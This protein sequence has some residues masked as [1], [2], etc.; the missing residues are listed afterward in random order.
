MATQT[1]SKTLTN[2]HVAVAT[3]ILLLAAGSA[4]F[5]AMGRPP[6]KLFSAMSV[7]CQDGS[8]MSQDQYILTLYNTATS[9]PEI[10]PAAPCMTSSEAQLLAQ[11][12]CAGKSNP[13]TRKV[14]VNKFS[15]SGKC[16]QAPQQ[17][18]YGYALYGYE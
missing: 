6:E 5:A 7:T 15:V 2:T 18:N 10:G 1:I 4:A 12:F 8:R 9:T 13:I 3:G 17:Q 11:R 14:G 16:E